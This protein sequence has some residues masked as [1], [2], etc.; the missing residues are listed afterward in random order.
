M[1]S[2]RQLLRSPALAALAVIGLAL[3]LPSSVAAQEPAIEDEAPASPAAPGRLLVV[4]VPG[5][6]WAD[7]EAGTL[8]ALDPILERAALADLA[9]RGV[10]ARSGP[11]DA[12]LTISGGS[13]ATTDRSVDGQVLGVEEESAGSV[14]G[15][16][17]ERR[18]GRSPS[19]PF[20]SLTWPSLVRANDAQPFDTRLGSLAEHLLAGGVSA[21]AIG[22][23]DGID[24]IGD[25][26]ERQAGLALADP[27]G[28][29]PGGSLGKDLLTDD[30]SQPFGLRLDV[31]VV[32]ERF[33]EAWRMADPG[34]DR[35]GGVV[36]VE[37][38]DLARTLRYRPIVDFERYNA[39]WAEALDHTD[40]LLT[41]MFS[42][43][44][45][46][47]DRDTVLVVAPYNKRGDR[48]LTAVALAGPGIEP[49]YLRSA[50]TQRSGFLTLVD[51]GPTILEV[52]ELERP[53]AMEG[54]AATVAAS[55]D[56]LD[57]R[58]DRL[59]TLND[60]SRFREQLLTPTTTV[61]VLGL[62]VVLALT[63]AARTNAWARRTRRSIST[64]GLA[65]L[66]VLPASYLARG[67]PLE[68]H[69]VGFYWWFIAG[70]AIVGSLLAQLIGRL[71]RSELVPLVAV[72][73]VVGG[74]LI[75]DVMTGSSLSL[76]AAFGYSPTGNSRL[77]GI[78]NYS[79]GQLAAAAC[80]VAGWVALRPPASVGRPAAIA[81][82]G[83][84]LIV[85]G[86]PVWG[87]DVGGVLAFTPA[88]GAFAVVVTGRRIRWRTVLAGGVATGLAIT[89][90][91]FLDLLRDP[92]DRSH[93]GRLFERVGD[94]GPAPLLS[95]VER[96]LQANLAVSTS[97]LWVLAV[98]LGVAFWLYLRRH[99]GGHHAQLLRTFPTLPAA[100]VAALVAAVLGSALNDSGAIIGGI[101]ATVVSLSLAVVLLADG[102]PDSTG[103][104]GPTPDAG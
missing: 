7:I 26:Y 27:F 13:R 22:N 74:V 44:E 67:F 104:H 87:S 72:L 33:T 32:T 10:F 36:L 45:V 59:I 29:V 89:V 6:T 15:E 55:D 8:P 16:I 75:V 81:L 41:S 82:M 47:L 65:V 93:L 58:I 28:V 84:V 92:S 69:G 38:S 62:A 66:L 86:V 76:N 39:M 60:A 68:D 79:Y 100:L 70:V 83:F 78:S 52:F 42:A 11:G 57:A 98:P 9:P 40:E 21:A 1:T 37:A 31:A 91:G 30:A 48:D 64:L 5:V 94:E 103:V 102:P 61:V 71:S 80:L 2:L 3:A 97:S 14:A 49:G 25:S 53:V 19:G 73:A 23:A 35:P 34:E 99:P 17:F 96:K 85:L 54:R 24:S 77:Y 46:D 88:V 90:F 56:P 43:A 50:S 101:M 18:T 4:S 20:V 95:M 51:V 63:I 12:Y